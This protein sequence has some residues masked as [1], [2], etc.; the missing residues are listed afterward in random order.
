MSK[1][2][3]ARNASIIQ[4][5][6]RGTTYGVLAHQFG[7]TRKRVRQIV[8]RAERAEKRRAELVATYGPHPEISALPDETPGFSSCGMGTCTAGRHASLS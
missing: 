5:R 6:K 4:L 2:E 7:L 3:D 1:A 8:H